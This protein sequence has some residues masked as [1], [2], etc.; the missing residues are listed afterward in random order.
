MADSAYVFEV[1]ESSFESIVIEQSRKVPVLVDF[2]AAWC[3]PCQSLMPVLQ[4]LA[5]EYQGKFILAKVNS[6]EQQALASQFGV[7]S[8]PTVK[9]F[10]GGQ[11]VDEFM[12]ALPEGQ[13][14]EFINKHIP[15]E[16]DKLMVQALEQ[17]EAGEIET[18]LENMKQA[19]AMDEDNHRIQVMYAKC[20]VEQGH[21]QEANDIVRVLPAKVQLDEQVASLMARLEFAN[22][23]KGAPDEDTLQQMI[24]DDDNNHQARYQLA[25]KKILAEDYEGAMTLLLEIMKRD[26]KFDDDA[27]RKALVKVFELLGNQGDLVSRFRRQM[28]ALVF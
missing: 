22:I 15:R 27:G 12:G 10:R 23:A 19:A 1:D 28:Q 13:V 21:Y 3:G 26:R 5:D 20:L 8:L 16:S 25:A 4:K 11:P 17:Y 2:W 14:R 18:A 24:T 6:D 9:L 7:R